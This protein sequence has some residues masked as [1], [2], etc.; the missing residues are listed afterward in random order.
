MSDQAE[1]S[2]SPQP[3]PGPA[4]RHPRLLDLRFVIALM[5]AIFGIL[6]T[7]AGIMAPPDQIERAAGINISLWTGLAMLALS[8]GMGLW[9]AVAPPDVPEGHVVDDSDLSVTGSDDP[10]DAP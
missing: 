4:P 9:V 6:V 10:P 5:F 2:A 8:A 7:G 3:A 1:P